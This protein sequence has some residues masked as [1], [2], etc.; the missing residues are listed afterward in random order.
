[1][2]DGVLSP[3]DTLYGQMAG[4]TVLWLS[5]FSV[6]IT[7]PM[8]G[9]ISSPIERSS[10]ERYDAT[11][12]VGGLGYVRI[13]GKVPLCRSPSALNMPPKDVFENSQRTSSMV[14]RFPPRCWVGKHL[15]GVEPKYILSVPQLDKPIII[16][17][18]SL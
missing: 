3:S 4:T 9:A 2:P 5:I 14:L 15:L 13:E 11:L 6:R 18:L 7:V 16:E 17:R 8:F 12:F 10:T 1:M